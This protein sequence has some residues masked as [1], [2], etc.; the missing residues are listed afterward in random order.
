MVKEEVVKVIN[1]LRILTTNYKKFREH[2]A[3]FSSEPRCKKGILEFA[4]SLLSY[5]GG[6]DQ[7]YPAV[8]GKVRSELGLRLTVG[9]SDLNTQLFRK[10][11]IEL[12][13]ESGAV[14]KLIETRIELVGKVCEYIKHIQCELDKSELTDA[15]ER[16]VYLRRALARLRTL[17]SS[18]LTVPISKDSWAEVRP[19][20]HIPYLTDSLDEI[21]SRYFTY[22][23]KASPWSVEFDHNGL[24]DI[25]TID[26]VET[27]LDYLDT[28]IK[29]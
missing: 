25:F 2:V 22:I 4:D 27:F 12:G 6:D 26:S 7:S 13:L 5:D 16:Q 28:F 19:A 10:A 11:L 21:I 1:E 29:Y 24:E 20:E 15:R 8:Y 3:T 9:K 14:N 18:Y 23:D 17:F